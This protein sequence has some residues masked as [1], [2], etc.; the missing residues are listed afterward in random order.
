MALDTSKTAHEIITSGRST[1]Q[2]VIDSDKKMK[3]ALHNLVDT[4]LDNDS[5][6][7]PLNL[8]SVT[9]P[10]LNAAGRKVYLLTENDQGGNHIIS[11]GA[12]FTSGRTYT[13]EFHAKS[14]GRMAS[15]GTGSTFGFEQWV[16]DLDTLAITKQ[17]GTSTTSTVTAVL[18][19][20]GYV[21]ITFTA[22]ATSTTISAF[23][24]RL[25]DNVSDGDT[26]YTGDGTSGLY[27]SEAKVYQS[28]LGPIATSL[29]DAM[30]RDKNGSNFLENETGAALYS[31]GVNYESGVGGMQVWEG[32]T[33]LIYPFAANAVWVADNAATVEVQA[34]NVLGTFGGLRVVSGG[35][36][37]GAAY[38]ATS[39]SLTNGTSY[40]ISVLWA[41]GTSSTMYFRCDNI[42]VNGSSA[43][44]ESDGTFTSLSTTAGTFAESSHKEIAPGI[45]RSTCTFVPN[46][47]ATGRFLFGPRSS[48]VGEYVTVYAAQAEAGSSGGPWIP[49]FGSTETR[50]A[51]SLSTLLSSFGYN[52]NEGTVVVDFITAGSDGADFPR[53]WQ[54]STS[55]DNT[56]R[57]GVTAI[58]TYTMNVV[59]N[60][61]V[62]AALVMDAIVPFE[63]VSI[64]SAF[65]TDDFSASQD[66]G[67][68]VTDTSGTLPT[69]FT[70]MLYGKAFIGD[71]LNGEIRKL[72][73]Y[74]KRLSNTTLVEASS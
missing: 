38:N 36:Q 35:N 54:L 3:W 26:V 45:Y 27:V 4:R 60:L 70:Q 49:T 43:T 8:S 33:N 18:Q 21:K 19:S 31:L 40:A 55:V 53:V 61:V 32:R 56:T 6:W 24:I 51:D 25:W 66:G 14:N 29:A 73:Y 1:G 2:T 62:Q 46:F 17:T 28:T 11:T 23:Q 15:V 34:E 39:Y 44:M 9:Q 48:T 50:G 30:Q 72:A 42:G 12:A 13:L 58:N 20:D 10:S 63:P 5:L 7:T 64:A 37:A 59:D 65:K 41:A 69:T 57:A 22:T 67:A 16:V 68:V 47:T 52:V 74:P 71:R